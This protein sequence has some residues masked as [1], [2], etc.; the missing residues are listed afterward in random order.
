[1]LETPTVE[2][3]PYRHRSVFFYLLLVIFLVALPFLFLYATG[4][5]FNFADYIL[6]STGGLYI[7]VERAEAEIYINNELVR[8]TRTFRR[9]FYAQN[10]EPGTH[11]IHVQKEDYHTWVKQLPVYPYLVTEAQA[12][13]MPLTP[14][15]RTI[16]PW[17]SQTG[18]AVLFAT[19]TLHASTTNE[20]LLATSTATSSLVA[21]TEFASLIGLFESKVPATTTEIA[22]RFGFG[23]EVAT[24][25][26]GTAGDVGVVPSAVIK[27][28]VRLYEQEGEVYA[29]FVGARQQ[30]PYYY[31]AEPFELL[32]TDRT[33]VAKAGAGTST[34]EISRERLTA[35]AAAIDT[36][37][38]LLD[39]VQTVPPEADCDPIIPIDRQGAEVTSFDFYPDSTDFVVM[40]RSD[41]VFVTEIDPR[42]WQN[43]QPLLLGEGLTVRI[44]DGTIYVYDGELIHRV[45]LER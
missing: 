33:I 45:I 17:Q 29:E 35:A 42:A 12:F 37:D 1:M 44:E 24:T 15:V 26:T 11:R 21:D 7:A 38:T 18:E 2:P 28:G 16:S 23:T 8:E 19:S 20:L 22:T 40:G 41:G 14:L 43:T 13:N 32:P 34:V 10:I 25:A 9:A 3:L 4:Y 6:V 27:N 30:M 31:C 36:S 39:P 5:R